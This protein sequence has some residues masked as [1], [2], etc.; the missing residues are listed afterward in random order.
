[1]KWI[2]VFAGALAM[3]A[4]AETAYVDFD[5]G[6]IFPQQLA[7]M[8]CDSVEKYNNEDLGY[9]VFYS[10]GSEFQAEVSVLNMG[11]SEVD[12]GP[13]A[14]G[15]D[16]IF[17]GMQMYLDKE[18]E[19]GAIEKLKKRGSLVVPRKSPLKF[20]NT[21]FQY[22]ELQE[23][24]GGTNSVARFN[25]VY[26]TGSH[27]HFIRVQYRFDMDKGKEARVMADQMVRQL[28]M[29]LIAK[30]S[31]DDLLLAACDAAVYNPADYGGSAA[32]QR[33]FAKSQSFGQLQVYD[34]F[35]V[36]PQDYSKPKNADL[37]TAAYFAGMLKVVIPQGLENGGAYEAFLSM[38]T[39]YENMR[40]RDQIASIPQLEEWM[41]SADRQKLYH[42]L[43]VEFGYLAE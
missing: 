27:N 29:L 23:Q 24:D 6:M 34:S 15:V 3:Q 12:T 8:A 35:F 26:V 25:S 33:V 10:L 36:W 2:V 32:A 5:L 14:D 39:S 31:E 30:N 11:R 16:M 17:R 1:M 40:A 19:G 42:K 18:Q 28:V 21:V 20:T 7:G 43:L 38:M 22:S 4:S 41:K 37:L 9:S 13:A